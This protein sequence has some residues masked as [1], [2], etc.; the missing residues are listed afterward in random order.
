MASLRDIKNRINST[1]S[2]QKITKA[3]EM[4]SASKLN[5]AE[6]NAK[7]FVPYMD[8]IQDVVTNIAGG[9]TGADHPMLQSRPVKKTGYIVITSDRGLAGP[10][11]SNVLRAL[12]QKVQN[13]HS[14]TDEYT[15]V[16][17]GKVGRDFCKKNGMPIAKEVTGLPD[18][19]DFAEIKEIASYAVNLFSDEEIDELHIFYNH[20]ISAISQ[21][22]TDKKVL[23]LTDIETEGKKLSSYE[24]EPDEEQILKTLLPQYAE[25]IVYGALLDG[26]ASEHASRM[27]AMRSATD[28]AD[29]LI[30]DLTLSYNRARQAAITQEITEIVGGAAALE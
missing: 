28:N 19:P 20:F 13:N 6:E 7:A 30:D 10:Y 29:E 5:K 4:V 17:L 2:T 26:K 12:N 3:M 11:N 16:P 9:N 15:V 27:T 23:P 25:S 22:V 18:Q 24:Y 21:K 8:K 14:S 1:K